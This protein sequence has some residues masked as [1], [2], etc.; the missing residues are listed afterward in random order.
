MDD[1]NRD[2]GQPGLPGTDTGANRTGSMGGSGSMGGGTTDATGTAGSD[3]AV[4]PTCGRS[5]DSGRG[6]EQFLGM[7]GLSDDM[8]TNLK[9]S[10]SNMHFDEYL[11]TAREYLKTSSGKATSYVKENP[12]KVAAGA[13]ALAVGAAAMFAA[14]NRNRR[15]N[16][17]IEI[18]M[19][20]GDKRP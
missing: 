5:A 12:G 8:I 18:V 2:F 7:I 14:L 15:G 20:E 3:V 13:A 17:E 11:G 6:L 1:Q 10:M 16:D 9:S 19:D 4:C